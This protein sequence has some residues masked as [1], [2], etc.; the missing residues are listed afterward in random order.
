MR[1]LRDDEYLTLA[2]ERGDR[3]DAIA[4]AKHALDAQNEQD[5]DIIESF[6]WSLQ[7]DEYSEIMGRVKHKGDKLDLSDGRVIRVR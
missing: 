6:L 3:L 1:K 5:I 2:I 7:D 4:A